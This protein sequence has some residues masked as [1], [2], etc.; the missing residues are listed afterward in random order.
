MHAVKKSALKGVLIFN[1][2]PF[3]L[4]F[5]LEFWTKLYFCL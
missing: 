5:S 2:K 3:A 4:A 1:N